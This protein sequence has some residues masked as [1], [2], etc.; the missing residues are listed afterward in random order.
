MILGI[1]PGLGA[2][3]YGIVSVRNRNATY[4]SSGTITTSSRSTYEARLKKLHEDVRAVIVTHRP[5]VVVMERPIYCQNVKTA[6]SLGQAGGVAILAA[7]EAGVKLVEFT[8]LQVK[9]AVTGKGNAAKEQVKKMVELILR[10]QEPLATEHESD[11]LA[12][13]ICHAHSLDLQSTRR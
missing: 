7:A 10:L 6:L 8:P 1:D 3:G 2:L 4:V 5:A 11:A 12:C 9:K 13:A